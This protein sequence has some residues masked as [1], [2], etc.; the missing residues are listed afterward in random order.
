[1]R[2]HP[3]V[4]MAHRTIVGARERDA[5]HADLVSTR[6]IA[7]AI[8]GRGMAPSAE[9]RHTFNADGEINLA[10]NADT[11]P[12]RSRAIPRF[13]L[14]ERAAPGFS[15]PS[16]FVRV[17][18]GLSDVPTGTGALARPSFPACHLSALP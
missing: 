16:L 4:A 10:L 13:P 15:R 7:F 8:K 18:E 5:A 9:V 6:H 2:E 11:R 1:M 12:A 14:R 3:S 17:G